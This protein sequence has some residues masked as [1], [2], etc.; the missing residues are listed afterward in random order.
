MF[1]LAN[2]SLH[3]YR[4]PEAIK[5]GKFKITVMYGEMSTVPLE[6]LTTMVDTVSFL[7]KYVITGLNRCLYTGNAASDW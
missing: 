7:I 6:Q 3:S 4:Y 5:K 2:N 1:H